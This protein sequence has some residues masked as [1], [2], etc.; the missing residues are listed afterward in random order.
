MRTKRT[1]QLISM[2]LRFLIICCLTL[3]PTLRGLAQTADKGNLGTIVR[4][5]EKKWIDYKFL[6]DFEAL[7]TRSVVSK[8][9][10]AN[11]PVEQ[12]LNKLRKDGFL[13]YRIESKSISIAVLPFIPLKKEPGR[14]T[15]KVIDEENGQAVSAVSI[16]FGNKGTTSLADGTFSIALLKGK[17]EAEVSS[18]GY[19][20]KIISGVEVKEGQLT[21]LTI[22]LKRNK[23]QL[24]AVVVRSSARKEGVNAHYARQKN[25]ATV[26]D[27][28]SSEQ[29]SRTPDNDMGQVLKRVSGLTTVDNKNVIVRGMSDR[30]NQAMLDGVVIPS[31]SMNRRNFSFDIIPVEMVSNVVVNKTAT[32]D[33]SSEFSGGQ[34]SI[35]TLDIP[36]QNFTT[37]TIGTGGNSQTTGKDFYQLGERK[38]SEYFGFFDK[39]SQ[40]PEGLTPWYWNNDAV[41]LDAPP[42]VSNDP[43]LNDWSLNFESPGMKYNDLDAIA[44]SRKLNAGPLKLQKYKGSPNQNYRIALGR[45]YKMKNN[46]QFGFSASANL[47]NEQNIIHFNNVRGQDFKKNY[48][49]SSKYGQNGAGRSYRFNSSS[50][51]VGNLGLQGDKFKIALKNMYARTYSNN[52]NEA[53]RLDYRDETHKMRKE[54][55]Q[56]PEAMSLQQHQLIGDY[57]LPGGIKFEGQFAYN[58]ISQQILDERKFQY[59]L[60]TQLGD[61]YYFQNPNLLQ[62]SGW[63]NN[64]VALDSR[65]WTQI[66]EQ[67]FNWAAN[68]SRSFGKGNKIKTIVKMGYQ[69]WRKQRALEV[70]RMLPMTR[71][72]KA[73]EILSQIEMPYEVLL[74]PANVG[75]GTG[76]AYYYAE[77][78]GG[79]IFDG[80]MNNHSMYL[81]ADQKL[82]GKLRLVYG[83]RLEYYDISNR[84]AELLRK[85]FG[86]EIPDYLKFQEEAKEQDWQLL[87]SVNATYSFTNTLNL[88][89]SYSKTAIR[90]DFRET[91]FFGFYDYELDANVS[92][93][94]V[95]STMVDNID[96]RL[97]WYPSP[98]EIIS[99]TG[100]YKY[101]DKPI[102]LVNH[103]SFQDGSYYVFANMASAKNYGL[104]MEVRKNLSFVSGKSWLSDLFVYANGTLL[105]STV[106]YEGPWEFRTVDGK[107]ERF[108]E[109]IPGM[110]RPLLGQSPWL[111]NLGVGY[112]GELFG[113][114]VSYNHRG[115]RSNLIMKD[116]SAIEYELAPKLLDF[117]LYGR[118]LKKKMEVKVNVAN[119]L[120]EW[121]RYYVNAQGYQPANDGSGVL[122]YD[123]V[124]GDNGY[125]SADGDIIMYRRQEGQ[126]FSITATYKF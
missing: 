115:Y 105:K 45:V 125:S 109:R 96:L 51:L 35:N 11:L 126:R 98:G 77:N 5:L 65:M 37:I 107:I 66:E 91:S 80:D 110:D 95:I 41:Q 38:S 101:L 118:F 21:N 123:R 122:K 56:L 82:F 22:T 1:Q 26:T 68:F 17:Y 90:P 14:V 113:A 39:S 36:S 2:Q 33:M 86:N 117:Q 88:R 40:K 69:G 44:Q 16:R 61:K 92:G 102:E 23:G 20:K 108:K 42:G 97:E 74:D 85:K 12:V 30:Y 83:A 111:L 24:A 50:G 116:P 7:Q 29:I 52:Y 58:K 54:I 70:F 87:P 73:G 112:W 75:A 59:R 120:N 9:D 89:A 55:Y 71:S 119:L 78:I 49:D 94:D 67:D 84:Q 27:G 31:T 28:I 46:L 106:N 124:K 121:T 8:P 99:L 32:P 3:T 47:R 48:I 53:V 81:M 34:V 60:T 104:E 19:G 10:I 64:T 4:E 72:A 63:S 57:L 103:P 18:V 62:H 13:T 114:T 100:Y 25:A 43:K 76:Q 79:N 93:Q 15:G 6:Y